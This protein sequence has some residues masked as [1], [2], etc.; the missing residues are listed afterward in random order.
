VPNRALTESARMH[1]GGLAG[2]LGSEL[3]D[4][5]GADSQPPHL[6]LQTLP[7]EIDLWGGF[8]DVAAVL[9]AAWLS[10]STAGIFVGIHAN[11][12]AASRRKKAFTSFHVTDA[13]MSGN[14]S[15]SASSKYVRL[16]SRW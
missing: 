7:V 14:G 8:G 5:L 16:L 6:L 13:I 15:A 4:V 2:P 11:K 9:A 10:H 3:T 12:L 1:C